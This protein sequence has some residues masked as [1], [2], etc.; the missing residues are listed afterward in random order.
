M[1]SWEP[2]DIDPTNRDGIGEEDDEWGD[3]LVAG[4]SVAIPHQAAKY[5]KGWIGEVLQH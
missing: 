1:A 2:G 5:H 4:F 3:D